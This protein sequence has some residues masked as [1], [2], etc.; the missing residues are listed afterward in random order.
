MAYICHLEEAFGYC[1]AMDETLSDAILLEDIVIFVYIEGRA[2]LGCKQADRLVELAIDTALA[3]ALLHTAAHKFTVAVQRGMRKIA[4][5][6]CKER[7]KSAL[8]LW[9]ACI[10]DGFSILGTAA[11]IANA[12]AMAVLALASVPLGRA[13]ATS[14]AVCSLPLDGS[15]LMD[16]AVEV[17][18]IVV[19]D[20]IEF[21][22]TMPV[23]HVF[24]SHIPALRS[25]STMNDDL[26][27][28]SH[29]GCLPGL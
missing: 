29:V 18:Q 19:A 22:G 3:D 4:V 13:V 8:L 12:D 16:G 25:G 14:A 10:H 9:C 5:K 15:T 28:C 21:P 17:N 1:P 11:D 6:L 23:I 7:R 27:D 24:D 20:T 2:G 26:I